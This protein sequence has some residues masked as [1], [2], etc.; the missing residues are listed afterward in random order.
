MGKPMHQSAHDGPA[1]TAAPASEVGGPVRYERGSRVYAIDGPVGTLR[2]VVV[3]EEQGEVTMLVIQPADGPEP[4]IVPVDLVRGSA[5]DAL[6]LDVTQEQFA[7]GAARAPRYERRHFPA[8]NLKRLARIAAGG[9]GSDRLRAISRAER[10]AVVTGPIVAVDGA[11]AVPRRTRVAAVQRRVATSTA[12]P[13]PAP[14]G[15]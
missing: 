13:V 6:L 9:F 14:S 3:D 2:Q 7:L 5:G 15:D 1:D 4:A 12:S 11:S 8:A 10:D